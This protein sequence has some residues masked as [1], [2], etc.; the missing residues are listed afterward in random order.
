M[1]KPDLNKWFSSKRFAIIFS[2]IVAVIAW[3]ITVGVYDPQSS[4]TI[5][6]VPITVDTANT[7]ANQLGLAVSSIDPETVSVS[8]TGPR[9]KISQ[10]DQDD[11]T[12]MPVSIA[13]VTG[14]DTYSL[15][16]T[17][18]LK[19]LQSDVSVSLI[20]PNYASITFDTVSSKTITLTAEAPGF[21]VDHGYILETPVAQ[22]ERLTVEGPEQA[23]SSLSAIK[24][25]TDAS[26]TLTSNKTVDATPH[27]YS[28]DGSELNASLFRYNT[29]I[30]FKITVPVYKQKNV[31]LSVKFKNAPSSLDV[32]KL[33]YTISPSSVNVAGNA[34]AT[35]NLSEINLGYVDMREL[36]IGKSFTYSIQIPSGFKNV[37]GVENAT[38]TFDGSNW[39]SKLFT[40][41]DLQTTN[42]PSN[43]DV[44]ID[45]QSIKDVKIVGFSDIISNITAADISATVDFTNQTL[46]VGRQTV[47][48]SIG[49]VSKDGVW[50]VGEYNC[51]ITVSSK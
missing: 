32:S 3:F 34:A 51:V 31:S 11:I 47:P 33:H 13:S 41:S 1:K 12:V 27:F 36:D 24:L 7:Q 10:M 26:G 21:Q 40:V 35:D 9:Y 42:V 17:A 8:V 29:D 5:H 23:I 50:A 25:I 15:Q 20:T 44:S 19:S 45:T 14:A 48:V 39:S 43:Y 22:P 28:L 6:G 18:S 38:V 49:I 30:R 4:V 37:D 46:K 16:L 2:L